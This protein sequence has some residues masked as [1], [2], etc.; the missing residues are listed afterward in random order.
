MARV[1]EAPLVAHATELGPRFRRL[2]KVFP[3]PCYV[4]STASTDA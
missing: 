2:T 4:W 3:L 1:V